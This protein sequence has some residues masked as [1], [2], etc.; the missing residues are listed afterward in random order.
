MKS[1]NC[2][3]TYSLRTQFP[4]TLY[5]F[6]RRTKTRFSEIRCARVSSDRKFAISPTDFLSLALSFAARSA[7]TVSQSIVHFRNFIH[8]LARIFSRRRVDVSTLP[9]HKRV[10]KVID[11]GGRERTEANGNEERLMISRRRYASLPAFVSWA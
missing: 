5:F 6:L 8:M 10:S 2:G 9:G 11:G 1:M 3:S 7:A 4:I